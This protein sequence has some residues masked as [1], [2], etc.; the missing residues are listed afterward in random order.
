M[1]IF[2]VAFQALNATPHYDLSPLLG[3]LGGQQINTMATA[4]QWALGTGQA[5]HL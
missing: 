5:D 2:P 4:G 1:T 3:R